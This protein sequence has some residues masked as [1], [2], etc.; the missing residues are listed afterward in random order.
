MDN[1]SFIFGCYL[2]TF[3][4]LCLILLYWGKSERFQV[5]D[6]CVT[7][8]KKIYLKSNG[9]NYSTIPKGE[10]QLIPDTY[11]ILKSN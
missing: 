4:F 9:H 5:Y 11:P 1:K 10:Y 2:T 7:H 3:I 8:D 6:Y